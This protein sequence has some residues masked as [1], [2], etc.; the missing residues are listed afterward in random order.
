MDK[1]L[2]PE[3]FNTDPSS[4]TANK[5]WS[6]WKTKFQK[7]TASIT[8]VTE[9]NKHDLLINFVGTEVYA[10]ISDSTDYN[11][12]IAALDNVF[13]PKK[14][15]IFAR[16]LL[17]T[18]KQEP[19]Q[20][21]DVYFQKLKYLAT[22]CDF[23]SVDA[24]AHQNQA[25]RESFISGL[26]S[27]DIRQ[28]L[29]ESERTDLADIH[30][31]AR[32]LEVAKVQA[33]SYNHSQS[34]N[35][36]VKESFSDSGG[37]V[38]A[39]DYQDNNFVAA[40][41]FGARF[42]CWFC[43][44]SKPHASREACPAFNSTCTKCGILGHNSVV[45]RGGQSNSR[46]SS[47][48]GNI[49][50]NNQYR[51][52][53]NMT[54]SAVPYDYLAASPPCLSKSITKVLVNGRELDALVDSGSSA[55]FLNH[56]SVQKHRWDISR[57]DHAPVSMASSTHVSYPVGHC[58]VDVHFNGELLS[59]QK[60]VVMKDLCAD[61]IIGLDI[62]SGYKSITLE[63][64]GDK[65]P[66]IVS[67]AAHPIKIPKLFGRLEE[68]CRPISIKSRRYSNSDKKF[69]KAEVKK[70]LE[71][72]VIEE[73][74]SPWRAQVLVHHG[75]ENHKKRLVI[76]YSQTINRFTK[77]D[78]YPVPRID[79][80][81]EDISK[82]KYFSTLDLSSAYHQIPIAE[83]EREYTAFE[84]DGKLYCFLYIPF[85]VTNGVAGFQRTVDAIVAKENLSDVYVYVDNITIGGMTKEQ[86]D[87][88]L[89]EFLAAAAKYNLKFN[90]SKTVSGVTSIKLL[91]YLVSH[92]SIKPDP[93]RI[94]PLLDMPVPCNEKA[95][96]SVLGLFSHYSKWVK[97]FSEKI[98]PL[99][100]AISFP[101]NDKQ[102][103]AFQLVKL[104]IAKAVLA[105]PDPNVPF[106]LE[107]DASDYAIG[108]TLNQSTRPVAFFSRTL[109]SSER[110]HHS[111]EKEAYAIVE[112]IRRWKHYL[113]GSQ[114]TVITDQQSV[115]FM[116]GKLNHGKIK[117]DKI[118]RWRIELSPYAFDII[119]RPGK[120][121]LPADA[122]S[123]L[124][125]TSRCSATIDLKSLHDQLCHPGITRM[126]HFV[127]SRNLPFSVEDIKK[128]TSSCR[129]CAEVK[130]RYFKPQEPQHLIKATAPFE[131][132]NLDFKGPLPSTTKNKFILTIVDEYSRYPFAFPCPDTSAESVKRCLTSISGV[133]GMPSYIHSDQGSGF[134]ASELKR[135][136]LEKGIA[137]SRSSRFNPEGNGQVE[138]YNGTV[139]KAVQ[140]A[141]RT[142]KLQLNCWEQVI[143]DVLHSIRSLLCTATNETPHERVFSFPRR[144]TSGSSLPAWLTDNSKALMKR[145]AN[146]SKYDPIVEEVELL[147][148]NP[149]TSHV[150]TEQGVEMTVSNKHLAPIGGDPLPHAYD[151]I[152]PTENVINE[153][154]DS[155]SEEVNADG[156]N[157]IIDDVTDKP[158]RLIKPVIC[159]RRENIDM[160]KTKPIL[161]RSGR[162]RAPPAMYPL[163]D[164]TSSNSNN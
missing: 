72:G 1:L 4:P 52:S 115:S 71:A 66:A 119:H 123:R 45:C 42:S 60:I 34:L 56:S 55:T 47:G 156:D 129:D 13:N 152:V 9:A 150:R 39:N 160:S 11:A 32:G 84:A 81:V 137:T 116:F 128:M 114:F 122:L 108:A 109:N 75:N 46:G 132:L 83:D 113:L 79:E 107:T 86:H 126:S 141:I 61:M 74:E 38:H 101:L 31:L 136:L 155:N 99:S 63:Y 5:E 54:S 158:I 26:R 111:V 37:T 147:E 143:T 76:D 68:N 24:A 133:F 77:L 90:E 28:R 112:A 144:S 100:H 8:D 15:V 50:R 29:L 149:S 92:N 93:D 110:N 121:N 161:R 91:G 41:P 125:P 151:N 124:V 18:C 40:A 98:H 82:Y 48:R 62:L 25:I 139:W 17:N 148:V 78:A 97:N 154:C 130:P 80:M 117:N 7:F 106:T 135:W 27:S 57:G 65:P 2:R 73:C 33:Q 104:D 44:G 118:T 23:K 89:T 58:T 146:R 43:G 22:D 59:D 30:S 95:L 20:S 53:Q 70:L 159:L 67:A 153:A 163:P 49:R 94:Q 142:R 12:S 85:G 88:N 138:K 134:M 51:N 36:V 96:K 19:E 162:D 16:H 102:K 145:H 69:I 87:K 127:R 131:R 35:A 10:H 103:E 140:L 164:R 21:I 64:G 6:H 157:N 3:T 105:T 120:D 14:N